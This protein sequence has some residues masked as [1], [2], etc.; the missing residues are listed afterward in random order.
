M[1]DN[2]LEIHRHSMAH[3][4]AA[5]VQKLWPEA[6]FGIGPTIENGFYY[7]I[8]IPKSSLKESDLSRIEKQMKKMLSGDT[9]FEKKEMSIDEAI[10]LFKKTKQPFKVELLGDI[11]EKGTT[12]IDGEQEVADGDKISIYSTGNFTD[13]CRGPHVSSTKDLSKISF[14]LQKLAGAYWRGDEKN[15]MLTR[16][17]GLAFETSSELKEYLHLL[18]EAEKRDHR[19][20]GKQLDLFVFSDLVGQGMPLYTPKGYI[21]RN[22]IIKYSGFLNEKIGYEHVHTPQMNK[23]ELFKKSG[24]Y[25]K[26]SEDMIQAKS[27]Y[28]DEEYFLKPMNCPQH[29]QIYASSKRSYRDLPIRYADMANLFRDEKP[30][31]LS[32]LTRL[33]CFSQDDG[34]S[35]CREDQIETEFNNVLGV[36][37]EALETYGLKYRIALSLWD[38]NKRDKYLGDEKI[39]EK[40]QKLLEDLLIKNKIEYT[41]EEGEAAFYGPKMDII[42]EDALKREFQIS[43]IQLDLNM[44]ERFSLSYTD[45]DGSDKT[46]VMIHRALVGSPE[47]FMGILIEHY[48]GAFPIW[49]SPVQI[50][51]ITVAETHIEHAKKLADEFRSHNLRAETDSS[52]ETVGN[53]I[54]KALKQKTPYMLVIGDKE[55][56]SESLHVRK[57]GSDQVDEIEK[58][59][60]IDQVKKLIQDKSQDL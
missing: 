20:I 59:K 22:E 53:K 13:L 14:K 32:G 7:D 27:H 47:R 9:K 57:R 1:P 11:K 29:T 33:R 26:F 36:I 10:E 34:H 45:K 30:G 39:W 5:A 37:N 58:N 41:K 15:P 55:I 28:S 52:N 31:E 2:Q 40:S 51:I 49:L 50:S 4:M 35:F 12:V 3:L 8:E 18:E 54:R 25:D 38:P 23:G 46:P 43:T 16:I 24:H 17:Y 44:P 42:A 21:V 19:K 48:A 6:K 60:F 56:A